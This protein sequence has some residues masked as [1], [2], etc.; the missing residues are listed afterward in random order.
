[1]ISAK[2]PSR[3]IKKKLENSFVIKDL[4]SYKDIMDIVHSREKSYLDYYLRKI[5]EFFKMFTSVDGIEKRKKYRDFIKSIFTDRS[6][7]ELFK[8]AIG[9]IRMIFG[10]IK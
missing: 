8:D 6:I 10:A 4:K 5:A 2:T 7:S 9:F 3:F 1:M